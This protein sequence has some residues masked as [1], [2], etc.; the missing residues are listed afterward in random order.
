M[1]HIFT[2]VADVAHYLSPVGSRRDKAVAWCGEAKGD[3]ARRGD[4][5]TCMRC[6]MVAY[7]WIPNPLHFVITV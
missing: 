4:F 2:D 7:V 3:L 1:T 6:A 5:V